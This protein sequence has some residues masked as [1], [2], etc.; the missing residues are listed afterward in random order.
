[1][2]ITLDLNDEQ[3]R[4]L[5]TAL[6]RAKASERYAQSRLNSLGSTGYSDRAGGSDSQDDEIRRTSRSIAV[7]DL[8]LDN[9]PVL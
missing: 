3:V 6:S 7:L 5:R 8:L 2:N 9:L 1:M 4:D